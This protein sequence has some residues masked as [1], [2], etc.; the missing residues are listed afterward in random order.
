VS[1]FGTVT[2]PLDN[3]TLDVI[4]HPTDAVDAPRLRPRG[5]NQV[6]MRQFN[7]RVVLQALRVHGS[8]PK[9]ELAR[10]TGLTAQTIGLITAR[11][12]EDQL[13]TREA[14]VRGRVGQPS[15]PIGLN[16]DGAFAVGIKIGRRSAD[17]LLVDFTGHVRQRIVLDY[18][19]PDA[20]TLLPAIEANLNRLLDGLGALR[21]RVV[22][23]GVAAPFQL[24]GWHRMLGLTE[25]QAQKWNQIDLAA[26][27]QAMTELP[28]SYAK[29]T[30]AACVAELLQGR[31]RDLHSFLYLFM[32]TFV[33]GGLVIDSHLHRGANGNAGAVASL[34]LQVASPDVRE[35]PQQLISQASLWDLE[36]RFREHALD[37]MAAYDER[38]MR[39]PWLPHTREWIDRAALALAHCIVA[40]TAFLD[41][42]AVVIDG[43]VAPDL[44]RDLWARTGEALKAYNQEGLQAM[45][46]LELG[47]IGSDARALGG[48]LLPLHACFAP[49]R[50]IFLKV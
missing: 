11:L 22:G 23:V 18:P 34:P 43:V 44:L 4:D 19:F 10:L 20:A 14:P 21:S 8:C 28:V 48:A 3:P 15:V 16:P 45:P 35:L 37:P 12:D 27:V 1:N 30:S 33:G 24:G 40:G 39:D 47:S 29:D 36:Q 25:A 31:G 50:D 32:D 2:E 49:D 17:W 7:E 6:G 5:S 41:V 9:A 42:E 26:R 38:A 13:L 46:R